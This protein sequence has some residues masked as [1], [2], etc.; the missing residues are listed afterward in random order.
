MNK[1]TRL[2]GIGDE[3]GD[4]R[5]LFSYNLQRLAGVSSR[6]A[7]LTIRPEFGINTLDWRAMAVLDFLGVATLQVLA[8]RA[9]VQKSQMSRTVSA[10]EAD[11][12]I[13]REDNP[14]DKRSVHLHLSPKGKQRVQDV[15]QASRDRNR[16]MLRELSDDERLHFM[17]L[18]EKVTIG[19][20]AYLKELKGHEDGTEPPPPETA[21]ETEML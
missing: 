12:M 2:D 17:A 19:S 16:A 13:Q 7:H 8:R 10:L 15:L 3:N 4:I 1:T 21:F 9:G 20:L 18:L 6:I 11:G 5:H 14:R